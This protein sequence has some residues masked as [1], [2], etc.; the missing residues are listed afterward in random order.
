MHMSPLVTLSE[1]IIGRSRA[2]TGCV[3]GEGLG[4]GGG[5]GVRPAALSVVELVR[6][7]TSHSFL[8]PL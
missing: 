7:C 5:G 6:M 3:W 8:P 2:H 4:W 1:C